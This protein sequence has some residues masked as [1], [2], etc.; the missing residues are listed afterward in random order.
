MPRDK[1]GFASVEAL[2]Q[3]KQDVSTGMAKSSCPPLRVALP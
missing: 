2:E 3:K 1:A